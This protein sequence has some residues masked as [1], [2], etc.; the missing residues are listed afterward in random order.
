MVSN[1]LT[2]NSWVHHIASLS[3]PEETTEFVALW[4]AIYG[5]TFK[6]RR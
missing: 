2:G 1:A 4:E 3:S 6:S 5:T